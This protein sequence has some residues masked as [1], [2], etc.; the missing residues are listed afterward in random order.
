[1]TVSCM[2]NEFH[3]FVFASSSKAHDTE[4]E[5]GSMWE[6]QM[7]MSIHGGVCTMCIAICHTRVKS[8]APKPLQRLFLERSPPATGKETNLKPRKIEVLL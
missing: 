6:T 8:E 4:M 3:K 7:S 1:M 2:F 5:P